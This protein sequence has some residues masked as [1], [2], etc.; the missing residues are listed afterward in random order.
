MNLVMQYGHYSIHL[1]ST[2]STLISHPRFA[3]SFP[4]R[5]YGKSGVAGIR[6]QDQHYDLWVPRYCHNILSSCI[7]RLSYLRTNT[8]SPQAEVIRIF[9]FFF[10]P[11]CVDYTF[12]Q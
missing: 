7:P 1:L 2:H 9:A 12:S 10:S 8:L 5:V 11:I 4:A 6:V 3:A